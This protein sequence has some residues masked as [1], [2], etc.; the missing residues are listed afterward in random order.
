M[1]SKEPCLQDWKRAIY[2]DFESRVKDPESLL[3]LA[4]EGR[5]SV[6]I[7][8]PELWS[9]A[10]YSHPKGEVKAMEPLEAF[11][12][13]RQRAVA[14]RRMVAAWSSREGDGIRETHGL[15]QGDEE[16]WDSNLVDAKKYAKKM[17]REL[18][19][20]IRPRASN[21]GKSLNK[22]SLASYM[23]ATG[24]QVP[25][26]HGPGNAAQ[27]ILYVRKQILAKGSFDVITRS[28]KTKWTNGLSHN[29][30]D[31]MGLR[32]VMVSLSQMFESKRHT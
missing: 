28:A 13:I 30:H 14:E 12:A 21:M 22:H 20:P 3:G 15:P 5:W 31:C 9:A 24:Y 8:E 27:R 7:L 4:C 2:I 32:H 18:K 26:I 16:W 10:S 23:E 17:A 1:L 25:A 29:Y 6:W 19:M 11:E